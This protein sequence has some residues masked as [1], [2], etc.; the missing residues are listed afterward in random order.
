[1]NNSQIQTIIDQEDGNF[2]P[3]E[4]GLYRNYLKKDVILHIVRW[5]NWF[6]ELGYKFQIT[7][8]WRP[9]GSHSTGL[10]I[11][12][13]IWKEW[14]KIQPEPEVIW[15]LMTTYPWLGVGIYFDWNDGVGCHLDL[16]WPP[17][18]DRPLRWFRAEG[19]YFYQHPVSGK[20]IHSSKEHFAVLSLEEM[21]EHYKANG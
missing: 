15:R 12:G 20:F 7:S 9:E 18:R 1:M 10:C 19:K 5:R 4:F 6:D 16:I 17:V 14:R 3:Q 11:D 13:L 8:G 2:V 21:I